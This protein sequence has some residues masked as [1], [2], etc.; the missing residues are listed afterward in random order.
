MAPLVAASV[1]LAI[2]QLKAIRPRRAVL[3]AAVAVAIGFAGL[4]VWSGGLAAVADRV[5]AFSTLGARSALW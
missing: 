3:I 4:L 1:W 5:V 2:P